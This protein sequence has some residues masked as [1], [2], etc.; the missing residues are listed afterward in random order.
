MEKLSKNFIWMG[1]AHIAGSI[2]SL[3]LG[4][5]LARMLLPEA[6]GYLSYVFTIIFFFFNFIDLGLSTFGVREIAS[7]KSRFSEYVSEIVSFRLAIALIL[8]ILVIASSFLMPK[9]SLVKILLVESSFLF[10]IW[11][12][13]TEW[14]FQSLEKMHMVFLS[15]AVTGALQLALIYTFVRGPKDLLRIPVL[16]VA[17]S[18][19]IAVIFL[20]KTGYKFKL[21][22][23]YFENLYLY[24]SSSIII[25]SISVFAQ[26]YNNLDLFILGLFRS[27]EEVGFFTIARRVVGAFAIFMIFLANAILPRLSSSFASKD[28]NEFR[29]STRK[30]LKLAA[31]LSVFVLLPFILFS[32]KVIAL[33]VGSQYAQAA[34]PLDIMMIGVAA[35][36]FN[37]PYSTALIAAH[38]EKSVL[39]QTAAS[40]VLS[41]F[42]NFAL[43]PKYGMIGA[44]VSFVAA[45][46]LALAWILWL[47]HKKIRLGICR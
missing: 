30:F 39:I 36:L 31:L 12:L 46:M 37:L 32:R 25:W 16:Y 34:V 47:Y 5:Y 18:I 24:L 14:A 29:R 11:A 35:I 1:A 20:K 40:A 43:I 21:P 33:T 13:S 44:S 10:F 3:I 15:S 28:I 4:V 9:N 22:R 23:E 19:P 8:F 6:L 45:E 2:F 27:I 38:F 17:A 26:I 7:N 42:L 41:I